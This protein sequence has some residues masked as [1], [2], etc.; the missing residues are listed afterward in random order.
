MHRADGGGPTGNERLTATTGLL[1]VVLLAIEA[2]TPLDLHSFLPVHIFLG[3]LLLVPVALKLA[4]AGWRFARYYLGSTPYRLLGPPQVFLRLLAPLL[5]VST[6]VLL[7]SGVAVLAVGHGGGLLLSVHAV[8]FAVWG[9]LV[10]V[11]TVAY[12]GRVVTV[13]TADW[14]RRAQAVSGGSLRRL[15]VAGALVAGVV[16]ALATLSV[17]EA[18]L[19]ARHHHRHHEH[20]VATAA[21]RG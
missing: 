19:S 20:A 16:V 2:T 12:L 10:A 4:S 18:W 11:H 9:G 14:R 5:V 1:L 13:G 7:G 15:A 3:L 6:V 8:S 17:Q 21:P